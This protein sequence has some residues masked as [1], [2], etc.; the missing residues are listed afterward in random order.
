MKDIRGVEITVG[1][2]VACGMRHGNHGAISV[3]EILSINTEMD[4]WGREQSKFKVRRVTGNCRV[5][6]WTFPDRMV[7]VQ[8]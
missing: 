3:G 1:S 4:E 6:T 8:R 7:V 2:I 5:S